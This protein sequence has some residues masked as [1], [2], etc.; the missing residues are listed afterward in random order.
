MSQTVLVTGGAGYIGS[1]ATEK[2]VAAGHEAVVFDNL[3]MGHR[4]AVHPDAT[5]VEGE[6]MKEALVRRSV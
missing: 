3:S 5:F 6:K 1:I 2:I 4:Q